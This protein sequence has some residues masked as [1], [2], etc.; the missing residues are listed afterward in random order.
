MTRAIGRLVLWGLFLYLIATGCLVLDKRR[1]ATV[2]SSLVTRALT[3]SDDRPP[4]SSS[5]RP[6]APSARTERESAVST[7][8]RCGRE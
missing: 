8:P 4:V 7:P 6:P 1:T 5:S 2:L 3:A